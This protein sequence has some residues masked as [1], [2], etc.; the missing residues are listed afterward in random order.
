MSRWLYLF[1]LAI[2]SAGGLFAQRLPARQISARPLSAQQVYY[3]SPLGDDA[4][5]GTLSHPLKTLAAALGR[6]ATTPDRRVSIQL[7]W[8]RYSLDKTLEITP[9][10]LAGHTLDIRPYADETVVL[11]GAKLILPR[12][13]V[14]KGPV[15]SSFI[16]KGLSIDQLYWGGKALPMAR[17]PNFDSTQT[18]MNGTAPDAISPA[19]VR[20]WH[21]PAGGYVHA[22]QAYQ[23]GSLDYRIKGRDSAGNLEM[24]GG[25]QIA[26]PAPMHARY[27]YVENI[28][29]ELDAPGEWY[30]DAGTGLLYC[31]LPKGASPATAAFERS[32][33][34][35]LLVIKGDAKNPVKDVTIENLHFSETNRT[36]MLTRE[37][38]VRSDWTIYRGGAV[39][40]EGTERCKIEGCSFTGLGG[41][42]I[43]ISDYNR[44]DTV[45]GCYIAHIGASGI[46]FVG[47]P[48][49]ARSASSRYQDYVPYDRLDT[50]VGPLT[51]NY[52]SLC[53][54]EDNLL[55]NL[56]ETE[57]QTAGVE[58][59]L[60]SGITVRHNTIYNVPRS[61]IN[62]G[63]GCWGGHV[64]EYNDVFNTVLETG[65][66]GAFNSWGRDRFWAADRSYMDSLVNVHPELILLDA[67]VPNVLR[68]NRFRCD[69]G[70][71]IDLDDGS[72][73]YRIYDNV[74]LNGGLKF[75]EGFYRSGQNNILINNSFHPH[76]W[77]RNSGDI[78]DHN[79]VMKPY[80]PIQINYWGKRVDDNLFPDTAALAAARNRGT[81]ADSKAG[82]P[83]FMDPATGDYRVREQSPALAVGFRNFPMD[84]FG[85]TDPA[86]KHMALKPEIPT[87]IYG[88]ALVAQPASLDWLGGK[89]K[90]VEGLADRS[91]YGLPD[92][93]GAIILSAPQSGQL[94]QWGI[95]ERD[96]VRALNGTIVKSA[97]AL[98]ALYLAA[99]QKG[100]A[101]TLSIIRNQQPIDTKLP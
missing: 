90:S 51:S 1:T 97:A 49:A 47:D 58:I 12:W 26:R 83:L 82:D 25:W 101:I 21:D 13:T 55:H 91:A 10:I 84:E 4:A 8:G 92:E 15:L 96:V 62:I 42:A 66:H 18:I 45:R 89:I 68:Y 54:A 7:R 80:F 69:H 85:V 40:L 24:E 43:M 39:V 88:A 74:C 56:G 3:V 61:G 28:L 71:D 76:V 52:P 87:L 11:Y 64:I 95:R 81:D 75:R 32:V 38:L 2:L 9:E 6:V 23:W 33:L 17:Y 67:I 35:D 41:N 79:I 99:H 14:W 93:Q 65:D 59:D 27:R 22:I 31:Y 77:F 44:L 19:R 98:P 48:G 30:Y 72:S 16:G 70:W 29:E 94:F 20:T 57:K 46:C 100:N 60:S 37:P 5:P 78:F 50:T 73:N 34:N 63:D 86:L 36:F 53:L